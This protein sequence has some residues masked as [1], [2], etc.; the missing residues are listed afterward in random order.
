MR[1]DFAVVGEMSQQVK[2]FRSLEKPVLLLGGTRGPSYL[3]AAL[4]E[5]SRVLL[6]ARRATLPGLDHS[7]PWNTERGGSPLRVAEAITGFLL[8]HRD[9]PVAF[10]GEAPPLRDTELWPRISRLAFADGA[11]LGAGTARLPPN[12]R[13]PS[14]HGSDSQCG[15]SELRMQKEPDLTFYLERR[16]V[17]RIAIA[18]LERPCR[19]RDIQTARTD[20]LDRT[21][22]GNGAL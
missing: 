11:H 19:P 14:A 5:L 12:T 3:E 20:E 21:S 6:R 15:K 4:K 2:S 8:Q 10:R 18:R 16:P 17:R 9:W 1:Y 22:P 7:G 13:A